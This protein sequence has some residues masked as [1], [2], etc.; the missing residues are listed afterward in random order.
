[1]RDVAALAALGALPGLLALVVLALVFG[2]RSSRDMLIPVASLA[3]AYVLCVAL[4]GER[5]PPRGDGACAAGCRALL[6]T[7]DV[8]DAR[9]AG[10]AHGQPRRVASRMLLGAFSSVQL[11]AFY[12][13]RDS[14]STRPS[15]SALAFIS[16]TLVLPPRRRAPPP[17]LRDVAF[18][19]TLFALVSAVLISRVRQLPRADERAAAVLQAGRRWR[20]A[21]RARP[22][23]IDKRPDDLT[24][25]ARSF[26]SMRARLAE[27]IGTDPLTGCLNRR[28]FETRLRSRA[29]PGEAARL[30]TSRCGDRPRPLQGD[31]RHARPSGRGH[32]AAAGSPTS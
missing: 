24:L 7:A 22:A 9:G 26:E 16:I 31:Q 11:A 28:A 2:E 29:A 17:A 30:D 3:L 19:L 12:F 18:N 32:R 15:C 13:G 21:R 5:D 10:V 4:T 14:A 25:L 23:A 8:L 20:S 1:M 27:Q 6:V